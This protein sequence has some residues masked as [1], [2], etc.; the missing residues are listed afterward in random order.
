[1]LQLSSI[2]FNFRPSKSLS[3]LRDDKP[4]SELH[5]F[6]SSLETDTYRAIWAI[7]GFIKL[8]RDRFFRAD[9]N[10]RGY[11]ILD[12]NGRVCKRI[13][14]ETRDPAVSVHLALDLAADST[15]LEEYVLDRIYG[16]CDFAIQKLYFKRVY[17]LSVISRC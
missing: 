1:M 2:Y 14:P 8:V 15:K 6:L 10:H 11:D 16:S 3:L 13:I 9:L 12:L 7:S 5:N 4:I 17:S